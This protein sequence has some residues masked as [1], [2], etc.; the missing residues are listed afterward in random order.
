MWEDCFLA[1]VSLCQSC[2]YLLSQFLTKIINICFKKLA[3]HFDVEVSGEYCHS[4]LNAISVVPD[5]SQAQLQYEF[6]W[7]RVTN[8]EV[9]PLYQTWYEQATVY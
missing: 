2:E 6:I 7:L 1:L 5:I 9:M 3:K 8:L 4:P